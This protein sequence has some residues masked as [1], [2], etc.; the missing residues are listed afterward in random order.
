[1]AKRLCVTME[2]KKN[3]LVAEASRG[4]DECIEILMKKKKPAERYLSRALMAAV[5][6]DEIKGVKALTKWKADVNASHGDVKHK[7]TPVI[8]AIEEGYH[9]VLKALLDAGADVNN[10]LPNGM[11]ALRKA[12]EKG[13][14]ESVKLILEYG[15]DVNQTFTNG[16]TPLETAVD[17]RCCETVKTLLDGGA[18]VNRTFLNGRT[19]LKTVVG[20]GHPELVKILLDSGAHVKEDDRWTMLSSARNRLDVLNVL[21]DGGLNVNTRRPRYEDTGQPDDE[22]T[23]LMLVTEESNI[24]CIR[25]LMKKNCEINRRDSE[26]FNALTKYITYVN[27]IKKKIVMLLFAAG[28]QIVKVPREKPVKTPEYLENIDDDTDLKAMCRK[29]IRKHLMNINLHGNLFDRTARLGLPTLLCD[30]L[31]YDE[32]L[33]DKNTSETAMT[34][35]TYRFKPRESTEILDM[36]IF[37]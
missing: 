6:A 37:F 12:V 17:R 27:T 25:L 22:S 4:H 3:R 21:L 19:L 36:P 20:R 29:T 8:H 1:M 31:V 5:R 30:F 32:L 34:I 18:H 9:D 13:C 11:V 10:A 26:G 15:A 23:L 2:G 35:D 24:E 16:Y 14:H 7:T 28:E 33:E